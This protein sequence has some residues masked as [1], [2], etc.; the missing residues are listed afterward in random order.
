MVNPL[1]FFQ[2]KIYSPV[3]GNEDATEYK[4]LDEYKEAVLRRVAELRDAGCVGEETVVYLLDEN[5]NDN[6]VFSAAI[7]SKVFIES[8]F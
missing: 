3:D 8:G 1:F 2:M 4:S 7:D 6:C 5:E